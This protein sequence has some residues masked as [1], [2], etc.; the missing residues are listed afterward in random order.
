MTKNYDVKIAKT[1]NY[2]K[3]KIIIFVLFLIMGEGDGEPKS[4]L[5]REI[6]SKISQ[7]VVSKLALSVLTGV[8]VGII[9]AVCGVELAFMFAI[10]TVLLNFIPSIGSMIATVLPLPVILLQFGLGW[11]FFVVL[12]LST[13]I[14]F[15]LGSVVEPKV[16]GE[17][18]DLHPIAILLFLMFW[19]LVWGIPGMFLAVPITAILKIIL[20]R[21]KTTHGISELLAG[22]LS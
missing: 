20:S 10:L 15:I 17:G 5:I 16:M 6:M 4:A 8:L 7:Y 3:Y 11:Q 9:L 13:I 18:M 2:S 21:I 14:Q 1:H 12:L 22:R 19:G